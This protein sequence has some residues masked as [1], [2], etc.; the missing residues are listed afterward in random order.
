MH[1]LVITPRLLHSSLLRGALERQ[2]IKSLLCTPSSLVKDWCPAT[3]ALVFPHFLS[4]E[5]WKHLLPFLMNISPKMPLIFLTPLEDFF[6]KE[7]AFQSLVRQSIVLDS[8][9][10]I[11]EIPLLIKDV[12]QKNPSS[13][14]LKKIDMGA[15]ILERDQR[16]VRAGEKASVLTKKEYFLLELFLRHPGQ[17]ISRDL[18][19]DSLWDKNTYVDPNTVDV[20][21]SRLRKKLQITH[22]DPLI[23]TI[24]SL[25]YQLCVEKRDHS[26]PGMAPKDDQS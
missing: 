8:S 16:L 5:D 3:D 20:T 17:I 14:P 7:R 10:S 24:P 2:N 9:L 25:G 4:L 15:F 6:F 11:D 1:T 18:I 13:E 26:L 22:K 19:M 21:M 12:I 23:K